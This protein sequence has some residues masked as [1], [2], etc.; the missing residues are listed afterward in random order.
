VP[1]T[2]PQLAAQNS[3]SISMRGYLNKWR[4][5]T[6]VMGLFAQEWE[7]RWFVLSGR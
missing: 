1:A 2:P 5:I 3:G 6:P 7:L 4:E